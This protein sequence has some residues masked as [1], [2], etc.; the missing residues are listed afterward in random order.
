MHKKKPTYNFLKR[1][2]AWT[3]KIQFHSKQVITNI[4]VL[5]FVRI[6]I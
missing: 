6:K 5:Y 3:G 1:A 4:L 2:L